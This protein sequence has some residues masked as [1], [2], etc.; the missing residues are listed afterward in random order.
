MSFRA[1]LA[2]Q[3]WDDLRFYHQSL[4][5]Q[6]L[7]LFSAIAFLASY[8]L[9]FF[10][11]PLAVHIGW[12]VMIPRQAGHFFFE[13]KTFDHVNGV[14]SQYKESIKIG[15]NLKRKAILLSIWAFCPIA[16]FLD[17]SF[18]GIFNASTTYFDAL[19]YVWGSL[20]LAGLLFRTFHLFYLQDLETGLVWITKIITDPVYDI[21][22]FYKSPILLLRG[23]K[24]D[25][26]RQRQ[27]AH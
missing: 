19:G 11:L 23:V 27:M 21:V 22:A 17:P 25:D 24:Y 1:K 9:L 7:H 20:A 10:D 14:T 6:T 3:R 18:Y 16:L 15:F 26:M 13:P 4:V 2:E 5:N 12:A 8:V